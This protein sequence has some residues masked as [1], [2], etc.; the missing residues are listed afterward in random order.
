M[1]VFATDSETTERRIE[2]ETT[3]EIASNGSTMT[4]KIEQLPQQSRHT[5][6]HIVS[7][8][9]WKSTIPPQ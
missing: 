7:Y 5:D 9:K 1:E 6:Q 4:N 8:S 3:A 2:N